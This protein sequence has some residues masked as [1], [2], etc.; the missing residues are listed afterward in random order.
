MRNVYGGLDNS[1]L[2]LDEWT[3]VEFKQI[4]TPEVL[5]KITHI[6]FCGQYGDPLLSQHLVGICNYIKETNPETTLVIHTNGSLRSEDWWRDFVNALPRKHNLVVGID[7]IDQETHVKYRIGTNYDKIISNVK[8]FISNGG[9]VTW[10]YIRFKHNEHQVDAAR[11]FA[12]EIGCKSFAVK[13]TSRFI[14][15]EPYPVKDKQGNILYYLEPATNT[16]SGFVTP[17][18]IENYK[19]IVETTTVDCYAKQFRRV[20]LDAS[21]RVFPCAMHGTTI[22]PSP[23]YDDILDPLRQEAVRETQEIF[24]NIN[25]DA[26]QQSLK[27][28]IDSDEWQVIWSQY[29]NNEKKCITCTKNCGNFDKSVLTR[30]CDEDIERTPINYN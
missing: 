7:G 16:Q 1:Y 14:N 17:Y 6:M 9:I 11:K 4:I 3:L 15:G 21:K 22:N 18:I 29:A 20:Y 12:N 13:D 25:N 2:I 10:D 30:F 26:T 24:K 23:M 27:E 5:E 19:Q 28:I 8:A